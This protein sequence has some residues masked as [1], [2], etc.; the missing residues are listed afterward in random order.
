MA[1]Q[2]VYD[3]GGQRAILFVDLD[4]QPVRVGDDQRTTERLV[5]NPAV[6]RCALRDA[7]EVVAGGAVER[8][9]RA[10]AGRELAPHLAAAL[11]LEAEA[12]VEGERLVHVA[13][14]DNR[15]QDHFFSSFSTYAR[16]AASTNA[17]NDCWASIA[18]CLT[19]R[20]S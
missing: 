14:V 15:H 17:D 5:G 1:A 6:R 19:A 4:L 3:S 10:V 12:L 16:S 9:P 7:L 18:A 2:R 20:I 13:D 11:E 8:E